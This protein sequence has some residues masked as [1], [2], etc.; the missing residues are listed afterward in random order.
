MRL[1]RECRRARRL[2]RDCPP[3]PIMGSVGTDPVW[4]LAYCGKPPDS[5]I[6]VPS[7]VTVTN[8]DPVA[9]DTSHS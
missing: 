8:T 1:G 9:V 5:Q 7:S 4:I 3:T 2:K 6:V